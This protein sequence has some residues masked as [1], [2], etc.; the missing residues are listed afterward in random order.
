MLQVYPTEIFAPPAQDAVNGGTTA[1]TFQPILAQIEVQKV[2]I[3]LQR[4][5]EHL[6]LLVTKLHAPQ[7]QYLH[8]AQIEA[9]A[10]SQGQS[11]I[12]A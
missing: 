4:V 3:V 8:H 2:E 12:F 7:M 11:T 6:D 10:V 5:G 9:E 1:S